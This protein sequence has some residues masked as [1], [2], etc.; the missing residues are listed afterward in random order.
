MTQYKLFSPEDRYVVIAV[1]CGSLSIKDKTTGTTVHSEPIPANE[2]IKQLM[3]RSI[4]IGI[5]AF[6]M[7]HPEARVGLER[8][9]DN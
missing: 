1:D 9:L 8:R 4:R 5:S 7:N 2:S 6:L 3:E